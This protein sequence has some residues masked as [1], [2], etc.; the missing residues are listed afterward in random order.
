MFQKNVRFEIQN[1]EI[2][3]KRDEIHLLFLKR[4]NL[5]KKFVFAKFKMSIFSFSSFFFIFRNISKISSTFGT[6]KFEMNRS[7]G[8]DE[9]FSGN[10]SDLSRRYFPHPPL[11]STKI[12]CVSRRSVGP[13]F[14]HFRSLGFIFWL[15]PSK[16]RIFLKIPKRKVGFLHANFGNLL[17]KTR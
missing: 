12:R 2:N 14:V 16:N 4:K 7:F 10:Y 11:Y 3:R 1:A 17:F 8:L 6:E 15:F 5:Q 9:N 13:L